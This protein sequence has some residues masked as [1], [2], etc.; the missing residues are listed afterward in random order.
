MNCYTI[1]VVQS[2]GIKPET[3][4]NKELAVSHCKIHNLSKYKIVKRVIYK[5]DGLILDWE[6]LDLLYKDKDV[7]DKPLFDKDDL[8]F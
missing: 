6:Y 2:P 1:Y 4:G 8:P 3:F 5:T 7:K